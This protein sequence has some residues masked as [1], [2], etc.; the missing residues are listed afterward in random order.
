[1]ALTEQQKYQFLSYIGWPVDVLTPDHRNYAPVIAQRF[2]DFPESAEPEF[3]R[4]LE[5]CTAIDTQ[6]T[7]ATSRLTAGS[8]GNIRLNRDEISMLRA[9]RRRLLNELK[10][11]INIHDPDFYEVI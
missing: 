2:N 8:I 5:Q 3:T 10:N 7:Q 6:L 11:I 4:R 9:E 1:M